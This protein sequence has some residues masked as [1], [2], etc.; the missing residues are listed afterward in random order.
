[1]KIITKTVIAIS[2]LLY[3]SSAFSAGYKDLST[4]PCEPSPFGTYCKIHPKIKPQRGYQ[5]FTHCGRAYVAIN[6]R[7]RHVLN[8]YLKENKNVILR[9]KI[10]DEFI[11]AP[12]F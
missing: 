12:C 10:D 11:D 9:F 1:M 6:A 2:S 4:A 3:F 5:Q 7:Q 8:A